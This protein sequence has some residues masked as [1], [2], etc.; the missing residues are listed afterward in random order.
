MSRM[1][2]GM[3][4]ISLTCPWHV[5]CMRWLVIKVAW[6]W[7]EMKFYIHGLGRMS[8]YW[9]YILIWMSMVYKGWSEIICMI[10]IIRLFEHDWSR[11]S[12]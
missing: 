6:Y 7:Y 11:V 5:A 9:F 4:L 8:W 1:V 12:A 10:N 2:Y 3:W